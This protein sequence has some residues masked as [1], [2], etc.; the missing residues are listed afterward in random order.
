MIEI[1]DTPTPEDGAQTPLQV[2][3]RGNEGLN[4]HSMSICRGTEVAAS[5]QKIDGRVSQGQVNG[6]SPVNRDA[7]INSGMSVAG[8]Q[9]EEAHPVGANHLQ[10]S[11]QGDHR[12][13]TAP[14]VFPA[15][16]APRSGMTQAP[17]SSKTPKG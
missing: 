6:V 9:Q 16:P 4:Q 5:S 13:K 14:V 10:G 15:N 11:R 8:R 12:V 3:R 2:E 7:A 1:Q 17:L